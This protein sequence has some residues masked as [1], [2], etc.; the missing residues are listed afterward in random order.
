LIIALVVS[1]GF[2]P[3]A[4]LMPPGLAFFVMYRRLWREARLW[5]ARRDVL[6]YA[7]AIQGKSTEMNVAQCIRSARSRQ[8]FAALAFIVAIII[9]APLVF[10]VI[11]SILR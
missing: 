11:R 1:I 6:K 3:L 8:M 9:N 2:L 7:K 10:L 5:R 4:P